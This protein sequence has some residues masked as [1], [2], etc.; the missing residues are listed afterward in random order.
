MH[1][2]SRYVVVFMFLFNV[3][4][5]TKKDTNQYCIGITIPTPHPLLSPRKFP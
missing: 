3:N 1:G 5:L 2:L 4:I